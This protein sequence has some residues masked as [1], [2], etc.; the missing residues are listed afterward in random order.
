MSLSSPEIN[1]CVIIISLTKEPCS[2]VIS[3]IKFQT[4]RL[5]NLGGSYV[6][7]RKQCFVRLIIDCSP[8]SGFIRLQ[9]I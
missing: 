8:F 7:F 6:V 1:Y 3:I 9:S 2:I 5:F 4:Y